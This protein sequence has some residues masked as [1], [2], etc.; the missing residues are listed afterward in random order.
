MSTQN[1]SVKSRITTLSLQKIKQAGEK[2]TSL[3]AYDATFAGMLDE[4]GVEVIL[5]GDSLGM[6]I[7]G[8]ETTVPVTMDDMVYHTRLVARACRRALVMVDMPFMSFATPEEAL[9]NAARLMREGGHMVKLEGGREQVEIVHQLTV[10]GI[11]VCAHIGLRPQ[12]IHKMGGYIIQGRGDEAARA[13]IEDAHALEQA[14]ADILLLE[15]VPSELAAEITRSARIPVI[16][17]GAGHH[18]DG[19]ILVLYDMLGITRG[20][21]PKFVKNFLSEG[22]SVFDAIEAYVRAVK[23]IEFPGPEHE[24]K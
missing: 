5:V 1:D 2:F 24:F 6:V 17:I 19:Q 18:C 10:Q 22:K 8:E 9:R 4:A 20:R 13:M 12:S 21:I 7:Q 23:T 15:C 3:T 11:P 16:G 14:G